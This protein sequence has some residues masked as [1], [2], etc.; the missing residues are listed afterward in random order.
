MLIL[1]GATLCPFCSDAFGF[2]S[3]LRGKMWEATQNEAT[4]V[5]PKSGPN[6]LTI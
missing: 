4:E 2:F 3:P 5:L 6:F 1:E